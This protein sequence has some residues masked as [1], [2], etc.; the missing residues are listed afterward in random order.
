MLEEVLAGAVGGHRAPGAVLASLSGN[1]DVELTAAHADPSALFEIGSITKVM[2]ATLA[3]QHVQRE[4][5]TLDDPIVHHLPDLQLEPLDVTPLVTVRHLLTHTS[6]IDCAD[7]F[8][9]TGD[10]DDCLE[11]Y[12]AEA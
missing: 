9:D 8:T 11:R 12:V 3:L 6:G 5:L 7:D 4:D 10:A 1:S 2:T